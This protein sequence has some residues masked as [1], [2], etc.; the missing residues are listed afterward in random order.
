MSTD[1]VEKKRLSQFNLIILYFFIYSFIGWALETVYSLYELGYITKR[2][3][4]F[5]PLCPIYGS[6]ALILL[7]FTTK[8]KKNNVSLFIVSA[9]LF[10]IFEYLVG[11]GLDALFANDWWDY[12]NEFLNLNGRVSILYSLIWGIFAVLFLNYM[13]PFIEKKVDIILTKIPYKLQITLLRLCI[14][15]FTVDYILSCIKNFNI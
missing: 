2:G 1:I 11:Y 8:F 9:I 4:L 3:F 15:V 13:H 10:T 14:L 12:T 5:G 6:G 7:Y